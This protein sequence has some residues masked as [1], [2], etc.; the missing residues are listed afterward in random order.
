M[1][2]NKESNRIWIL[3]SRSLNGEA[4]IDDRQELEQLLR[5]D[6]ALQQQYLMMRALWQSTTP[7]ADTE[8]EVNV[9]RI[10]QL[11]RVQ[12]AVADI[13]PVTPVKAKRFTLRHIAIAAA[14]VAACVAGIFIYQA[15]PIS[16][17]ETV[18]LIVAHNGSRTQSRLPDG[19]TVWLNAG[20][21]LSY[22][23]DFA[24][25]VRAVKLTGE[26]Y[27]DVAPNA[28][29][30]FI[31]HT[32]G[33]HIKVLG[34]A[35]NV[36]AYATDKAVETTLISGMVQVVRE[37]RAE[38]NAIYLHPDEKLVIARRQ[39]KAAGKG[40]ASGGNMVSDSAAGEEWQLAESIITRLDSKQHTTAELAETAWMY[41][42][43]VFSGDS[44]G[45]LAPRL[46]RWYNIRIEFAGEELKQLHFNG[47]FEKETVEQAFTALSTAAPFQF[48]IQGQ[49]V[50]ISAGK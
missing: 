40:S 6:P 12:E 35:F 16:A 9:S 30:P 15:Y 38:K 34:T 22:E 50:L 49:R 27:F 1:H 43:L 11:A 46:E 7:E 42:R 25:A 2:M 44:F 45:E 23:A 26:A 17:P 37:D 32:S 24:G 31:V 19:S 4:D 36:K 18:Q 21:S 13:E 33:I 41:N 47:S 5:A 10:L 14:A 29:K 3:M 28:R 20:S 48:S 39:A 8:K